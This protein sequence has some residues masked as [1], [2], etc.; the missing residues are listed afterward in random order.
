MALNRIAPA[1]PASAMKTYSISAPKTT[2]T[3]P[4]TCAEVD[5]ADYANGWR[6]SAQAIGERE[7]AMFRKG[8]WTWTVLDIS[9]AERWYIFPPGQRCFRFATH[10]ASLEREPF[11]LVKG[12]DWRGDPRGIGTKQHVRA[13]DWV[14]DCA[15][16]QI[17][18][19]DRLAQG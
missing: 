2:H 19:A 15:N 18:L 6:V 12:G 4:A 1:L 11:Y 10:R 16:H 5:C 17:K 8:G 3:R 9:E 7:L 13:E 14:D